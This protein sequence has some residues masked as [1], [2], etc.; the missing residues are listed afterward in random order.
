[1][2]KKIV[3]TSR[4]RDRER[5]KKGVRLPRGTN[6]YVFKKISYENVSYNPGNIAHIL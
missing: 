6:E 1:M 3:V 4:E 2:E 5:N